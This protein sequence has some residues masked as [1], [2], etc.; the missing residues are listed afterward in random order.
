MTLYGVKFSYSKEREVKKVPD[1]M[2][3]YGKI[4]REEH[5]EKKADIKK[6]DSKKNFKKKHHLELNE[7]I[8]F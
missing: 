2:T 6:G 5:Y 3:F 8:E 7:L 1:M 4:P